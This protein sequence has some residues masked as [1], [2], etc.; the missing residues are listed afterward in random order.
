MGHFFQWRRRRQNKRQNKRQ[1][2]LL[3]FYDAMNAF[4]NR[5]AFSP[6]KSRP[7]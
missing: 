4:N 2:T 3:D 7:R 5:L 1:S 6:L